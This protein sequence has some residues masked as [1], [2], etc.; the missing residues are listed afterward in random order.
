ME[1][2]TTFFE[3]NFTIEIIKILASILIA[4]ITA[5]V[6]IRNTKKTLT[7]QYFKE[8]GSALQEDILKFWC[9]LYINNFDI[10]DTYKKVFAS[11]KYPKHLTNSAEILKYVNIQSSVYCSAETLKALSEYQQFAYKNENVKSRS[12]HEENLQKNGEKNSVPKLGLKNF[13]CPFVLI[14]RIIAGMK[15][16]FTGEK[17]DEIDIVKLKINDLN[18]TQIIKFRLVL[19]YFKLKSFILNIKILALFFDIILLVIEK[20]FKTKNCFIKKLDND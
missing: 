18:F 11:N 20:I 15:Y 10:P 1:N 17:I 14:T 3:N 6:A 5:K 16:D 4:Y 13:I 8:K 19:L 2:V 12:K 7:T 9:T